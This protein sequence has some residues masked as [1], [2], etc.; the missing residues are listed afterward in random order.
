MTRRRPRRVERLK[1]QTVVVDPVEY[2]LLGVARQ[3]MNRPT[4]GVDDELWPDGFDDT[5]AQ[6]I[7]DAITFRHGPAVTVDDVQRTR[8]VKELNTLVHDAPFPERSNVVVMREHGTKPTIFV[9]CGAGSPALF[10]HPLAEALPDHPFIVYEQYGLCA[11]VEP[12]RTVPAHADRILS[13]LRARHTDGPCVIVAYSWGGMPAYTAAAALS[14]EGRD[15]RFIALDAMRMAYAFSWRSRFRR[16]RRSLVRFLRDP[17]SIRRASASRL[18]PAPIG[19]TARYDRFYRFS[20]SISHTFVDTTLDAPKVFI[21][22]GI[23]TL[24]VHWVDEPGLETT[25]V[26][27][28]H[29]SMLHPPLIDTVARLITE[30]LD[31]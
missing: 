2:G 20:N 14:A 19:S 13:D 6:R 16:L 24:A 25:V 29:F 27:G 12:D 15:V 9:V 30:F 21:T 23:A 7:S 17:S 8:T 31:R 1:D 26:G 10:F 3:V 11:E 5:A 22:T 28:D 18:L 4:L